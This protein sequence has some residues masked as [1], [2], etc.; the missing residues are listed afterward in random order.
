[1]KHIAQK[2]VDKVLLL[3]RRITVLEMNKVS[4]FLEIFCRV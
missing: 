3:E 2:R 1:M 4:R